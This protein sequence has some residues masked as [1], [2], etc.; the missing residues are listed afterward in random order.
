MEEADLILK[1]GIVVTMNA[2]GD[3]FDP[4]AVVVQGDR[5][6]AVGP[7]A[8]VTAQYTAR[9]TVDCA[10]QAVIPGL[11][12]AHTHLPM[13]LLRGLADDRRLDVWLLGYMMPVE[14]EFVNPDFVRLGTL[15]ACAEMIRSGVT[16]FADMYYYEED[17][18]WAVVEA[19][20][21]GLCTQTVLKFPS[22]DAASYEESLEASRDFIRRWKGHPLIVPGVAP[23]APYT[24]T[25]DI[26]RACAELAVEFD[27]P[28]HIHIAETAQEVE[29]SRREHG[30][31]VVPWVKKQGVLE[32]KVLAA[33]CVH[34]DAGEMRTLRNAGAGV[35]HNPT[36]NLK[37][38]SGIAPVKQMLEVGLHVGI[39]TDGPASNNDL[40]MFEEM[41]LAALLAKGVSGDPTALP[42]R[43]AL[44]LATI[45]GAR[46]LHM[47]DITGSLEPGKRADMAIVNLSGLHQTPKFG[48]EA[49]A[50]YAQLVYTG[51]SNDVAHVL[52]NGRWLM[53]DR[54][55][56]TLDEGD[57]AAQAQ[58]VAEQIDAF[59]RARE[60]DVLR[61]LVSIGGVSQEESFEVQ[62]KAQIEDPE[63][64]LQALNA[65]DI[66]IVKQS[67]YRQFDT[68]LLF[69][70]VEG[71]RLRYR[72]DEIQDEHGQVINARYRLTLTGPAK[73]REF[74][75]SVLLSRSRYIAPAD[76]SLRFYREYFQPVGEREV[77]KER[78]RWRIRYR[79]TEFAINL[80]RLIKPEVPGYF[81]EIK[82]RT[83]SMRDAERKAEMIGELLERFGVTEERLFAPEYVDLT[84]VTSGQ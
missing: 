70:D 51:K 24:C 14:R 74:A 73:E 4:G 2:A 75:H 40:D 53:R 54:Q 59:L 78:R 35:A 52:C 7:V 62:V 82:S 63:R 47:G 49:N 28:L 36:S 20:L 13:T 44:A 11:V 77:H 68:Y 3:V 58:E 76:R 30:M 56:L 41:R 6:V 60:S 80:D 55:L 79:G 43:Q 45:E 9:E 31:P 66:V 83:W 16:C 81:L 67:R 12:N 10:G 29:D 23:H 27:V 72:E 61:K 48:H 19:G 39:G 37:L 32:A 50:I 8:E 22:P 57:L 26:L 21:R 71:N 1:G 84:S 69:G 64:I 5:I 15:L 46:A 25:E 38:S 18:A 42:A 65:P 34:I 17:I 33:H